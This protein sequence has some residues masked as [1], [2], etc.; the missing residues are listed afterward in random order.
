MEITVKCTDN[1]DKIKKWLLI[2][3]VQFDLSPKE[4][5]ILAS[6]IYKYLVLK[7]KNYSPEDVLEILFSTK[8]RKEYQKICNV[9]E[10]T[11]NYYLSILKKKKIIFKNQI[12]KYLIPEETLSFKFINTPV[13]VQEVE[14]KKS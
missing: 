5:D 10:N 1:N 4:I 14:D 6:I 12:H 11:F 3:S 7:A 2:W 9:N 13:V 8:S